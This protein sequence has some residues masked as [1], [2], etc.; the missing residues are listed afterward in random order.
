MP[1]CRHRRRPS[2]IFIAKPGGELGRTRG[3]CVSQEL[4]PGNNAPQRSL[5]ALLH[6]HDGRSVFLYVVVVVFAF[7]AGLEQVRVVFKELVLA[8]IDVDTADT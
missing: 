3:K 7:V 5:Q 8:P 6:L 4:K 2:L 1:K